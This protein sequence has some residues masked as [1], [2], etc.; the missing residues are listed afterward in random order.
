MSQR[1]TV[2]AVPFLQADASG[3]FHVQAQAAKILSGIKGRLVVIAVAGPY[4]TGKSFLLNRLIEA[5][6][7]GFQVGNTVNACTKGIWLWGEPIY[8]AKSDRTYVFMDTEGLNSTGENVTYDT[9]IFALSVLL[10]SVFVYNTLNTIT[11]SSLE[12]LELVAEC[13][14]MIRFRPSKPAHG[15]K[16]GGSEGK[17]N[18]S[19]SSSSSSSDEVDKEV[20]EH[21]PALTWVLRDFSLNLLDKHGDPITPNEYLE[22][23]LKPLPSN[24]KGASEKNRIRKTI[25]SCF[26]KRECR[27]LVR[28]VETETDLRTVNSLPRSRIRP[29]FEAAVAAM[30]DVFHDPLRTADKQ[31]AGRSVNGD[32]L[33]GLAHEYCAA[34]N[35][36]RMP[37]I[38]S[39]WQSVIELRIRDVT[40]NTINAFGNAFAPAVPS[41]SVF[42]ESVIRN[43]HDSTLKA[44]MASAEIALMGNTEALEKVRGAV[45]EAAG[46]ML[47]ERIALNNN[48]SDAYCRQAFLKL[49]ESTDPKCDVSSR[50]FSH[51]LKGDHVSADAIVEFIQKLRSVYRA[52]AAGP[53]V[54]RIELE[55]VDKVYALA[56]EQLAE[57]YGVVVKALNEEKKKA[58][59]LVNEIKTTQQELAKE[60]HAHA[61]S[62]NEYKVSA[63]AT[64]AKMEMLTSQ[65]SSTQEEISTLRKEKAG[66]ESSLRK[67]S[68]QLATVT[69]AGRES[70]HRV[71]ALEREVQQ[72]ETKLEQASQQSESVQ[73]QAKGAAAELAEL[74]AALRRKE[75]E[76]KDAS[77]ALTRTESSLAESN[78]NY[79]QA[80]AHVAE[81]ES[82]LAM[83]QSNASSTDKVSREMKSQV[84]KYMK[85]ITDQDTQIESL[86]QKIRDLEHD[87]ADARSAARRASNAAA[88]A[89]ET[90]GQV[91]KSFSPRHENSSSSSSSSSSSNGSS[92][93]G[94]DYDHEPMDM[95]MGDDHGDD[96]IQ[97]PK[98]KRARGSKSADEDSGSMWAMPYDQGRKHPSSIKPKPRPSIAPNAPADAFQ[99]A[100]AATPARTVPPGAE[101]VRDPTKLTVMQLMSWLTSLDVPIPQ[102]K[103][104]T[105]QQC[106]DLLKQ[107]DPRLSS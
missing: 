36:G 76:A 49:W 93:S 72:L 50:K 64:G 75:K 86:Q 78:A 34:L 85:R 19:S 73:V 60:K 7:A 15:N 6:G 53:A 92:S 13:S 80:M 84:D 20:A 31:V 18:H 102:T 59:Q 1:P 11:E 61:N 42:E 62:I 4:R 83:A 96:E 10:S 68:E 43:A 27:P 22:N 95:G 30:R 47:T 55:C 24:Y 81:L 48:M 5:N 21:F 12:E 94:F 74:K 63:A 52:N 39:A 67:T 8:D 58:E 33:V 98:R 3:K 37:E 100:A 65:L 91:R 45:T 14:K 16:K 69:A 99:R 105:K 41:N 56:T 28:P 17:Q 2:S 51:L 32:A 35:E 90:I 57:K 26:L 82:K 77:V 23:A 107:H 88:V 106:I 89:V 29:E 66:I 9:H 25:T 104:P 54:G 70:S 87:L 44:V 46:K 40:D 79:T 71:T 103:K 101:P 97:E 38:L